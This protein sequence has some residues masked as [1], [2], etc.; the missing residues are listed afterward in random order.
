MRPRKR[1][2]RPPCIAITSGKG[3]VGKTN[4]ADQPR[5]R[6]GAARPPRRRARRRLRPRQR[7]RAARPR[8]GARTSATCSPARRRC[9]TII[10]DGP[11]GIQHHSGQL[12]AAVADGARPPCSGRG[13]L[14]A[15]DRACRELDF[16]LIDTATGISDN[17]IETMLS[18]PTA[19]CS[20]P[21]SSRRRSSTPTRIDQGADRRRSPQ[22]EIGVVVNG[23]RDGGR[24]RPGVPPARRRGRPLPRTARSRYDGYVARRPGGARRG[25]RRSARSS[26]TLPQAPASRC[27]RIARRRGWRASARRR[28]GLRLGADAATAGP[29]S[30]ARSEVPR[31][32]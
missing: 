8:A 18:W 2:A 19:S 12:G 30:H 1:H 26:S 29:T 24:G 4:V 28:P 14:A 11:R 23:A 7:R 3:G 5:R 32:A 16:L 13:S 20:S 22:A 21:R 17:V 27:F 25:A 9:R 15:L 10:V 31:C 6:H